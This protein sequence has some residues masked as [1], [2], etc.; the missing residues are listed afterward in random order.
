MHTRHKVIT[1]DQAQQSNAQANVKGEY[2]PFEW[3][4]N[5]LSQHYDSHPITGK[6]GSLYQLSKKK[7]KKKKKKKNPSFLILPF[8][9]L[10]T[11]KKNPQQ[12]T[13]ITS[14]QQKKKNQ[15]KTHTYSTLPKDEH[16]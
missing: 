6:I 14:E 10:K 16:I 13:H 8:Q 3:K 5:P 7:K 1:A 2:R 9:K 12:T 11:K 4:E 15:K